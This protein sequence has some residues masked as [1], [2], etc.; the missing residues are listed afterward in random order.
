MVKAEPDNAPAE[1]QGADPTASPR[2]ASPRNRDV[3][4]PQ[5]QRHQIN[6]I[7]GRTIRRCRV[8]EGLI[9]DA[10]ARCLG[11]P[12]PDYL[13]YEQGKADLSVA[14]L[15]WLADLFETPAGELLSD[16]APLKDPVEHGV[17]SETERA[18][19]RALRHSKP[20]V[21]RHVLQ[22][23]ESVGAEDDPPSGGGS[24]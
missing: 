2:T 19:I 21:A 13:L 12:L 11:L 22:L 10:A 6:A 7:V 5:R 20:A 4:T 17:L 18:I 24:D 14:G 3:S 8:R 1:T 15:V 16:L 9:P 23:L